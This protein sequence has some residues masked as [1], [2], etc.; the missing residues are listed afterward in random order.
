MWSFFSAHRPARVSRSFMNSFCD[1]AIT[2]IIAATATGRRTPSGWM[3]SGTPWSLQAA[4][5][6]ES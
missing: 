1:S 6:T 4:T 5:S 3:V 2:K